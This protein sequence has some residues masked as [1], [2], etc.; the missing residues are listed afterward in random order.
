MPAG[1]PAKPEHDKALAGTQ[2]PDRIT[3]E[4]PE[5]SDTLTELP[6]PPYWMLDPHAVHHWLK[7]GEVLVRLKRLTPSNIDTF[8]SLCATFG[9]C[10][11][12]WSSM[13]PV[14]ASLIAQYRALQAEF[15]IPAS[16]RGRATPTEGPAVNPFANNARKP[17]VPLRAV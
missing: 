7:L 16:M 17:V 4:P 2:R 5:L 14:S 3:A 11:Q 10:V 6:P 9:E 8:G 13:T 12:G 15:V 1:R